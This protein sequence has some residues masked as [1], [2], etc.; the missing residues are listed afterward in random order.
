M[1]GSVPVTSGVSQGSVLGPI[2]FLVFINYLL[3]KLS[4]QVRL[5]ADNAAVYHTV[6]G[7][8]DGTVLQ[9]TW[10]DRLS[11]WESMWDMGVQPF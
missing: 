4:S 1:F 5:F 2:L 3:E 6:R 8:D 9:I 10:T 7:S 11:V